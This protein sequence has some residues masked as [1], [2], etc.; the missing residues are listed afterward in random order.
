L[1][2]TETLTNLKWKSVKKRSWIFENNNH[3][4]VEKQALGGIG[5]WINMQKSGQV[6]RDKLEM[7]ISVL[8][9]TTNSFCCGKMNNTSREI[10]WA[11]FVRS[12][13]FET[14]LASCG[15]RTDEACSLIHCGEGVVGE[16]HQDHLHGATWVSKK[17]KRMVKFRIV[18]LFYV[19]KIFATFIYYHET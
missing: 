15:S 3:L 5:I 12:C 10:Y 14:T 2:W 8:H 7:Y 18:F 9:P 19:Y 16:D 13:A 17:E 4:I 6:F 11:T 1:Y